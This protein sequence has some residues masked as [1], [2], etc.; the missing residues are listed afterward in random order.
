MNGMS[1]AEM[2]HVAYEASLRAA[3]TGHRFRVWYD[4]SLK[5]W[6]YTDTHQPLERKP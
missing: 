5:T 4:K 2:W 6:T 1:H 3:I